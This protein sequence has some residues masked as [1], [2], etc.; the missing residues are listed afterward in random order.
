MV[1]NLLGKRR[2]LDWENLK[3]RD[4]WPA[5][6]KM[7]WQ[8]IDD[9]VDGVRL[10]LWTAATNRLIHPPNDIWVERAMV[11]DVDWGKL[12]IRPRGLESRS[13]HGCLRLYVLCCH[14]EVDTFLRADSPSRESYQMNWFIISEV[15]LDWNRSLGLYV[16]SGDEIYKCW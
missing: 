2:H 14:M 12:L 7:L 4:T 16:K 9:H 5:W 15:N 11:D 6:A 1:S 10:Y 3:G 8:Y 13:R